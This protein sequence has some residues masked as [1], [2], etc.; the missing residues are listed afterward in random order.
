MSA[1]IGRRSG[2][3]GDPLVAFRFLRKPVVTV[4]AEFRKLEEQIRMRY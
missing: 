3:S 1:G 4:L 2:R